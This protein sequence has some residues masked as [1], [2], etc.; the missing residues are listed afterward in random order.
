MDVLVVRIGIGLETT[1]TAKVSVALLVSC[2][3]NELLLREGY[4]LTSGDEVGTLHRASC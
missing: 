1:L 4:K 3:V 2:T